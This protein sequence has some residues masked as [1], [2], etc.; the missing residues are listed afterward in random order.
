MSLTVGPERYSAPPVETWMIPSLPAS[1]NPASAAFSVWEEDTL[2]A[3]NAN[4]FAFAVSDIS[5][6]FSGVAIGM[7]PTLDERSAQLARQIMGGSR[8]CQRTA[9]GPSSSCSGSP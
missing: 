7:S 1:A 9:T 3:G 8:R 4:D 5:A 6:Y 2:I